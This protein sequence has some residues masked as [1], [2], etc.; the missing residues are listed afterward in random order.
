[1][2]KPMAFLNTVRVHRPT[3]LDVLLHERQQVRQVGECDGG[4]ERSG[5][6]PNRAGS[7]AQLDHALSRY[8]G[9][10]SSVGRGGGHR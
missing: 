9:C 2:Q 10:C 8:Q 7:T 6:A 4:T 5:G 3:H 1:M